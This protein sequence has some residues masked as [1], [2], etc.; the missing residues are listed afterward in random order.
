MA[1]ETTDTRTRIFDSAD[2]LFCQLGYDGVSIRDVARHA[3]VNKASVFYYFKSKEELFEEVLKAYYEKNRAALSGA[4]QH[5]GPVRERMHRLIDDYW[6]FM[7]Q[8]SRY[9]RLVLGLLTGDEARLDAVKRTLAPLFNWTLE[10]LSEI[11]PTQGP[12][13]ARHLYLTF[14]SAVVNYFTYVPALEPNWGGDPTSDACLK[15]RL[16]HIHWLVDLVLDDL[17]DS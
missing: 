14:V 9:S 12:R 16:E 2:E 1:E 15:E 17:L 3:G 5:E 13:A 11:S 10:A 7:Q 4:L 6:G 8:N